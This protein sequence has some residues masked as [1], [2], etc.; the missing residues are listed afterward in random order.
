ME[1]ET[2][3][4][5]PWLALLLGALVTGLGHIYLRRWRRATGWILLTVG[6]SYLFVPAEALQTIHSGMLSSVRAIAPVLLVSGLSLLDLYVLTR[7]QQ[8]QT[9]ATHAAE[10]RVD[11]LTC[12]HCGKETDPDLQ[13]CQ[14]CTGRFET[15]EE[16]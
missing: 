5:R 9:T 2:S 7:I 12:P 3:E 15:L 14:W 11:T 10:N 1:T 6:A 4:K 13:F 8:H 16:T